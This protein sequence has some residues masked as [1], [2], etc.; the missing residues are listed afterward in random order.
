[1]VHSLQHTLK[2]IVDLA[3]HMYWH[4]EGYT[5]QFPIVV[6]KKTYDSQIANSSWKETKNSQVNYIVEAHFHVVRL[7]MG[8]FVSNLRGIESQ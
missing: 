2:A 6:A 3:K 1:M 4:K 5:K 7:E 8:E